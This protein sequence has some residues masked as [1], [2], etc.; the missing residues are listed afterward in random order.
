M[1]EKKVKELFN[2]IKEPEIGK[3][4]IQRKWCI[5]CFSRIRKKALEEVKKLKMF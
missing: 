4:I 1:T 5:E 2:R 3:T